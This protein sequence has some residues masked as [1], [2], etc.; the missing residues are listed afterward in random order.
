MNRASTVT[1]TSH[2]FPPVE[3]ADEDGLLGVGGSLDPE[4]LIDAY[5]H[6]I[7]PWPV[8][9]TLAW[10]S[11]DP[12]AVLELDDLKISRR[13]ARTLRSDR[14]T[15]SCD[16]AFAEVIAACAEAPR[17]DG[18]TWITPEMTA[19]YCRLHDMGVAHSIEAWCGEEL[20]GGVYGLA[21]GGFFAGESMFYHVTD[22]SKVALVRLVQHLRTRGFVLFDLQLLNDH[23]ERLGGSEIPRGDYMPRLT[24]ALELDVSFGTRIENE[25]VE[26]NGSAH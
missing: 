3:L 21:F 5:R 17:G 18:G 10:W 14:F 6:G 22:A 23:T 12:R 15:V 1:T 2:Y 13:L 11:P 7:F 19:A 20:V 8:D 24:A 4:W 9:D 26:R 25:Q 16:R